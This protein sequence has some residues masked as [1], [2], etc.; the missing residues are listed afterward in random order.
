[1]HTLDAFHAPHDAAAPDRLPRNSRARL[2]QVLQLALTC[3]KL[4]DAA[5]RSGDDHELE[6]K[7][8]ALRYATAEMRR[9]LAELNIKTAEE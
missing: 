6:A 3:D 7:L 2:E 5:L 1:M 4:I 8:W 9:I